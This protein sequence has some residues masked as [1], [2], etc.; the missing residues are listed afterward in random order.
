MPTRLFW[1]YA[2][3][4][5]ILHARE[6]IH[7]I[8]EL[9]IAFGSMDKEQSQNFI[10]DLEQ[11]SQRKARPAEVPLGRPKSTEEMHR[12]LSMSSS[13]IKIE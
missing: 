11:M 4:L 9:S 2:K 13:S 6:S 3:A 12:L 7:H 10:A 8:N 5:P 1:I